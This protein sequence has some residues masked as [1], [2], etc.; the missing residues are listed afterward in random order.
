MPALYYTAWNVMA[1]Q[2]RALS[3]N[4]EMLLSTARLPQHIQPRGSAM[5]PH[6]GKPA[7]VLSPDARGRR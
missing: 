3:C 4:G 2:V 6:G 7:G 1:G 5:L